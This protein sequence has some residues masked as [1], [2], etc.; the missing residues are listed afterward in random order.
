M[1]GYGMA[2]RW[3]GEEFLLIF[4]HSEEDRAFRILTSLLD[5]IRSME[6]EYGGQS[7]KVTMTFGL[8][9]GYTDNLTELLCA[10]DH[11]LYVGKESGRNRIVR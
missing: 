4:E 11:N 2:A 6:S 9:A 8:T 3:G 5:D 10:A 1:K 7:V